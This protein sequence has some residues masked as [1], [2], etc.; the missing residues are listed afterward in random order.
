MKLDAQEVTRARHVTMGQVSRLEDAWKANPAASVDDLDKPGEDNEPAHV[1]LRCGNV[2][3]VQSPGVDT[4]N[5][6]PISHPG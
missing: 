5:V 1:A 3:P 6:A 4:H 2:W